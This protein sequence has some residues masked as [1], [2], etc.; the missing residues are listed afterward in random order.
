MGWIR[1][2]FGQVG[3]N[4]SW[5]GSNIFGA[6]TANSS[7]TVGNATT[8]GT[9]VISDGAADSTQ[10]TVTIASGNQTGN[11]TVSLPTNLAANDTIC[12][13][14]KANCGGA[15]L[16]VTTMNVTLVPEY[17]GA[18]FTPD[19]S[20]NTG[21][22]SSDFCSGTSL[23]GVNTTACAASDEHNFYAWTTTQAT[24]QDYDVYVRWQVPSDYNGSLGNFAIQNRVTAASDSVALTVYKGATS[25]ATASSSSTTWA[26]TA[27]PALSGCTINAG[28]VLTFKVHVVAGASGN[29]ARAGEISFSYARKL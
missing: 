4:N 11:Y 9:V 13:Q 24:A 8:V 18:T 12:L 27:L 5:T 19:G 23:L 6:V 17:A 28:D 10:N 26:G 25:C 2:V 16:T 7:V 15:G 3:S 29:V 14:T 20:S 22:L 21:S 1:R